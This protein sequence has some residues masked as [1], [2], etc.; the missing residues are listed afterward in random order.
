MQGIV[1][2][3]TVRKIR[4]NVDIVEV[5]GREITL[6]KRGKNYFGLCPFH[7]D[8]NPSLS[9]SKEKQIYKC[10]VCGEAGNVFN[11]L[12]KYHNISFKEALK[13]LAKEVGI[14]IGMELDNTFNK[15][16]IYYDIYDIANKF[17][18]NNLLSKEGEKA[19]EYLTSRHLTLDIIKEFQIGLSLKTRDSLTNLLIKKGYSIKTLSDSGLLT[20]N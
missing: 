11:F 3:D 10:F 8:N 2:N 7:N 4:E 9:V 5:I 16:K 12:M 15:N 20:D 18:Q 6:E 1:D 17:Y 19:R 14:N 13:I